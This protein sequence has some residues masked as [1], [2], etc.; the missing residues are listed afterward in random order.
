MDFV[1]LSHRLILRIFQRNFPN[2]FPVFVKLRTHGKI[3]G[4]GNTL[5]ITIS[6]LTGRNKGQNANYGYNLPSFFLLFLLL[7]RLDPSKGVWELDGHPVVLRLPCHFGDRLRGVITHAPI[8]QSEPRVAAEHSWDLRALI[9]SF[10]DDM[11]QLAVS[12]RRAEPQGHRQSRPL[13]GRRF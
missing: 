2:F 10:S 5:V 3:S 9:G 7:L 12:N 4:P 11:V 1:R 8:D 6:F 13:L